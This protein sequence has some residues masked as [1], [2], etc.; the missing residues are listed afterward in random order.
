MFA[1]ENIYGVFSNSLRNVSTVEHKTKTEEETSSLL[2]NLITTEELGVIC[3]CQLMQS[4]RTDAHQHQKRS[5]Y[6]GTIHLAHHLSSN[7]N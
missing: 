3:R 1:K 6:R 7:V 5:R 4:L 2:V